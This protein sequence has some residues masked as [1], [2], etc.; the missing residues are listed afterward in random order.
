MEAFFQ[1][2]FVNRV[3]NHRSSL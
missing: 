3:D 2:S 1:F